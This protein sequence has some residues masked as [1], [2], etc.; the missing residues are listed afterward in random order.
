MSAAP[1]A[2][3]LRDRPNK[4][5]EFSETV[6]TPDGRRRLAG[7]W[8]AWELRSR[9]AGGAKEISP[10]R[11]GWERSDTNGRSTG[12]AADLAHDILG[13]AVDSVFFRERD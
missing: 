1:P 9:S 8:A 2:L 3:T 12:G 10:A 13:I 6:G 7:R 11:E 5:W 4:T